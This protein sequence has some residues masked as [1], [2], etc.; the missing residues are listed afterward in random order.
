[1]WWVVLSAI[2]ALTLLKMLFTR[3]PLSPGVSMKQ[4]IEEIIQL[5]GPVSYDLKGFDFPPVTGLPFRIFTYLTYTRFGK[6]VLGPGIVKSSNLNRM[7]LV[8]IPENPTFF[9]IPNVYMALKDHSDS[10]KKILQECI[11]M[12][13]E[14]EANEGSE[15]R[16]PTIADYVRAY[17]SQKTT[18]SEV[19]KRVLDA[20]VDSD[21]GD[22]PLRAVVQCDRDAVLAMAA[23]SDLRWREGKTLSYLD[24]VPVAIKE[25]ISCE[26][27]DLRGGASF[28]PI[29]SQGVREA[30]CV[31]RLKAAGAVIIGMT[32][33]HELGTGTLGSNPHPPQLTGRN[34]YD[35]QRYAGGSST[36][37]AISVAAGFCPVALGSDA[38]GSIRVPAAV[39]GTVGLKPTFGMVDLSGTLPK[40]FTVVS[41]GPLSSSVLDTAITMDIISQV[42]GREEKIVS[43][44]GVGDPCVKGLKVG[45]F[46]DHFNDADEEIVLKCR[47]A[48]TCLEEFGAE[49]V[50]IAIPEMEDSRIAHA[51]SIA[52]EFGSSLGLDIDSHYSDINPETHLVVANAVN[53]SAIEYINSQKQRTRAMVI[54]KEIFEKVD[55]IVTPAIACS[56]PVIR[57]E[58][59]SSGVADGN[60]GAKMMRFSFLGNLTGIPGLVLP[61][62]YTEAGL[63]VGFQLMASWYRE[64]IL[65]KTGWAMEHSRK[66]PAMKPKVFYNVIN[67]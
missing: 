54:L 19:A 30:T 50:D 24:G 47:T 66:F 33:M 18:P 52:A 34:P 36:G 40:S 61:V 11:E 51:I 1:M 38:G 15:F 7:A 16:L 62:G 21:K 48:L 4:R 12:E 45:V 56:V 67:S 46:W 26:P 31:Q 49:L 23:A 42:T 5:Q 20:V 59:M 35:P 17:R 64:D 65:L 55:I 28:T 14:K 53:M 63:P 32:N 60:A 25:E 39:C 37:S 13:I 41:L 2:A 44:Q 3:L 22:P 6:Y 10:N 9:P 43:L 57:P 29:I 27:Y 8:Q 58:A